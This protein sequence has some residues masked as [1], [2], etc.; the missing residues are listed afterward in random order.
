VVGEGGGQGPTGSTEETRSVDAVVQWTEG[1][2]MSTDEREGPELAP[3]LNIIGGPHAGDRRVVAAAGWSPERDREP[4][5]EIGRYVLAARSG[6][7]TVEEGHGMV[8]DRNEA[9]GLAPIA[10]DLSGPA[11]EMLLSMCEVQYSQLWDYLEPNE[12]PAALLQACRELD[13]ISA[14][15]GA[16]RPAATFEENARKHLEWKAR[17][18]EG[19]D[20]AR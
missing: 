15:L 14:A 16:D 19:S 8:L 9:R 10:L 7:W 13:E 1:G 2:E 5:L 18:D 17:D 11:R 4:R 20:E 3:H 6:R 12:G